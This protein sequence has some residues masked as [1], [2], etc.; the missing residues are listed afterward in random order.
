MAQGASLEN[1]IVINGEKI[2][3]SGGL[4]YPNEFVRHKLLDMVGDFYLTGVPMKGAI[5]ALRPGHTI[6]NKALHKLFEDQSAY[7]LTS[8]IS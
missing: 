6:N 3:N 4:R 8:S 1:V 2:L 7:R 5:T